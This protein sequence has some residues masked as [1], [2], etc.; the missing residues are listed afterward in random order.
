MKREIRSPNS[1]YW[2]ATRHSLIGSKQK[3][4]ISRQRLFSEKNCDRPIFWKRFKAYDG[5]KSKFEHR[6]CDS[7]SD[8]GTFS[9]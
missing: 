1:S 8:N 9:P 7:T 6:L 3:N 2:S 5:S 4:S